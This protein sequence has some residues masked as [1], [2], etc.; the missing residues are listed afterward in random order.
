MH[1]TGMLSLSFS[2]VP[3]GWDPRVSTGPRTTCNFM[4]W[5][6][7]TT[8][9][10]LWKFW[11]LKPINTK[12][13]GPQKREGYVICTTHTSRVLSV[14]PHPGSVETGL[15]VVCG[16]R[17]QDLPRSLLV[18]AVID[19]PRGTVGRP[20]LRRETAARLKVAVC[21]QERS[22]QYR[23]ET[24]R[25]AGGWAEPASPALPSHA[26]SGSGLHVFS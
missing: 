10:I 2:M 11:I 22:L 8:L 13:S 23:T 1:Y 4:L 16:A 12:E 9:M 21:A 24:P 3:A 17:A 5:W 14:F 7:A 18:F 15:P 26:R 19:V 6:A 20:F 25:G